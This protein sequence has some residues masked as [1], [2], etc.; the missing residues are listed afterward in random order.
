MAR[1]TTTPDEQPVDPAADQTAGP[2]AEPP[3]ESPAVPP[4][5]LPLGAGGIL[6]ASMQAVPL[7]TLAERLGVKPHVLAGLKAE[8]GWD[9]GTRV[10]EKEF[11]ARLSEWLGGRPSARKE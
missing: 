7:D 8:R 9:A 6:G 10:T 4:I 11:R 5:R 2:P 1:R 3:T